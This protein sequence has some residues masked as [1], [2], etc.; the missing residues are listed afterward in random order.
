MDHD[1]FE[2]D[3]DGFEVDHD[4]CFEVGY[5]GSEVT[6]SQTEFCLTIGGQF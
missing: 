2:V 5:H 3:H 4:G 6:R 1:G